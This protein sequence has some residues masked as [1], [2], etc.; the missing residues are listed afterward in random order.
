[1]S[2]ETQKSAFIPILLIAAGAGWLLKMQG[3]A[4]SLRGIMA[5]LLALCA[6]VY[7]LSGGVNKES[8]VLA[9]MLL[10]VSA[11]LGLPLFQVFSLSFEIA[12]GM[13]LL[14][15]LMLLARLDAV[16]AMGGKPARR[17]VRDSSRAPPPARPDGRGGGSGGS[18]GSGGSGGSAG[19][20]RGD[21]F[22]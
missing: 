3:M 11:C 16:P 22:F 15:V 2:R 5:A 14:G 21:S 9:P 12:A 18:D 17:P 8:V 13:V 7:L 1:M 19:G 10:Y 4:P 20:D 6:I